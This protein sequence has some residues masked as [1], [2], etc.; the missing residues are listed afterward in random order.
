MLREAV[1]DVTE[2]LVGDED[3]DMAGYVAGPAGL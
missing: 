3:P 1:Q 2:A